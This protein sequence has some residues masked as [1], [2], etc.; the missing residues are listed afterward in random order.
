MLFGVEPS[1]PT[2]DYGWILPGP[3]LLGASLVVG[4]VRGFV[5]KPDRLEAANLI[6]PGLALYGVSPR[7]EFQAKFTPV[8]T[9]KTRV[10]LVREAGPGHSVSYGRTFTTTHTTRIAT[11]AV[12]Y[13]D[14]RALLEQRMERRHV[15]A[16]TSG[17][18]ASAGRRSAR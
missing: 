11:L 5:E 12:G 1:F 8:L 2:E 16:L 13:A 14:H 9:W 17:T 4:K 10:L 15:S 7:P 18:R 3:R 6:R